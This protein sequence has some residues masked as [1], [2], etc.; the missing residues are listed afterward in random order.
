MNA[1]IKSPDEFAEAK[2]FLLALSPGG[3]WTLTAIRPFSA[4]GGRRTETLFGTAIDQALAFVADHNGTLDLH[5]TANK[6]VS[7]KPRERD[8]A[9]LT[10]VQVD[11]DKDVDGVKLTAVTK[12]EV[13]TRLQSTKFCK[14]ESIPG[15]PTF[16][17]DSG[18]GLQALWRIAGEL[19][20]TEENLHS[21]KEMNAHIA[22]R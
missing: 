14:G 7:D 22:H 19:A 15:P 18:N 6:P 4:F 16:I 13:V 5:I 9:R 2:R 3:P 20:P 8:I 21:V 11:I 17:I 12:Q 10:Y 1:P